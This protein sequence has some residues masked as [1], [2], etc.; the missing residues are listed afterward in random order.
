MFNKCNACD[1]YIDHNNVRLAI[2]K[3]GDKKFAAIF[4]VL[5]FLLAVRFYIWRTGLRR[6][7]RSKF[8]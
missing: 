8:K 5:W 4:F 1:R 2:E 3:S 7:G 6:I